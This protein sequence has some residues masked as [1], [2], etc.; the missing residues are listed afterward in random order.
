MYSFKNSVRKYFWIIFWFFVSISYFVPLVCIADTIRLKSG[1]I[2]KGKITAK[3]DK[4]TKID[5]HGVELTFYLEEIDEIKE[6]N[7]ASAKTLTFDKIAAKD[8]VLEDASGKMDPILK[9]VSRIRKLDFKNPVQYEKTT[10]PEIKKLI[11]KNLETHHSAMKAE[12]K[13]FKKLGV[14]PAYVDYEGLILNTIPHEVAGYYSPDDKKLFIADWVAEGEQGMVLAHEICHALQDQHFN[15]NIFQKKDGSGGYMNSDSTLAR[16]AVVEGEASEVMAGY[17]AQLKDSGTG[18]SD[19]LELAKSFAS[20]Y[21]SLNSAPPFLLEAMLFPYLQ[22]FSFLKEAR[23][24]HPIEW[25]SNLYSDPPESSEQIMHPEKYLTRRDGPVV[26]KFPDLSDILGQ[27]WQK[28]HEDTLGEFIIGFILRQFCDPA[29]ASLSAEGW[30]GDRVVLFENPAEKKNILA[31]FC[32]WDSRRDAEEFFWSYQDAVKN[33]HLQAKVVDTGEEGL[34]LWEAEEGN[35][36]LEI[37]GRGVLVLEGVSGQVR[38]Q[39]RNKIWDSQES[40]IDAAAKE[41]F[42]RPSGLSAE[43]YYEKAESI[44]D[45]Y[46][47]NTLLLYEALA[48][49]NKAIEVNKNFVQAY[50]RIAD[51]IVDMAFEKGD[52]YNQDMVKKSIEWIEKA[53]EINPN[54][55]GL[56]QVSGRVDFALKRYDSAESLLNK[57]ISLDSNNSKSY[58]LLGRVYMAKKEHRKAIE[59]LTRAVTINPGYRSGYDLLGLLYGNLKDYENSIQMFKKALEIDPEHPWTWH[60]YSI[61][62]L[63]S[64][65][66]DEAIEASKSAIRI[67]DFGMAHE[68]LGKAYMKKGMYK[69]AEEEFRSIG[70]TQMLSVLYRETKRPDLQMKMLEKSIKRDDDDWA[71]VEKAR[72]LRDQGRIDEALS[73]YEKAI[74]LNPKLASV[75][76]DMGQ[77]YKNKGNPDKA[78]EMYSKAIELDPGMSIAYYD[79]GIMYQKYPKHG[80]PQQAISLLSVSI[81]LN[82]NYADSYYALACA[83]EDAEDRKN[84]IPNFE[85]YLELVPNGKFADFV[86]GY[87]K[88]IRK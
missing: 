82:P 11:S 70:D 75:Y 63:D 47:G 17:S 67:M 9:A 83:Y 39:L 72:A 49:L 1:R 33:K 80:S 38:E 5:F 18:V 55:P 6:G 53:Q 40:L 31:L 68:N 28:A 25:N 54:F 43:D 86:R 62:L 15:L 45:D 74:E 48:Y 61:T 27:A 50:A 16:T 58:Y 2:V 69:E 4:Y 20:G 13:L 24:K 60:N 12:E 19:E 10:K 84:A 78:V 22:G 79:L 76:H 3:T 42:L 66:V 44:C 71:Y 56:Y 87:L 64:G 7:E 30:G 51:I 26:V 41:A 81:K 8:I 32:V 59:A 88:R 35:I 65:R 37:K 36:L 21:S 34:R 23:L 85:K 29:S 52:D 46:K 73:N 77:I 14:L 57:S